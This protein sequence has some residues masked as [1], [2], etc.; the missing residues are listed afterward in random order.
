MAATNYTPISLY[1]STTAS[2]SPL[3]GNLTN[4]ELAINITDGKLFYKDNNGVVQTIAYKNTPISTLSGFGTGVATALG[5]NTGSAG[6]FVVNGGA[7]GTPSSGTL[8]NATGLPVSTGVSGFGTGVATALGINTGSAGAFVVNGGALGTPSSGTVTNLTGT[9]SINI[10]GTVGATTP[11]AG[12]FT[13]LS[14]TGTL[15]GGTGV[16]NIGSGQVYKDASGNVGIGTTSPSSV[17]HAYRAGST[18]VAFKATNGTSNWLFG[19]LSNGMGMVYGPEAQPFGIWTNNTERMRIDSSGNVGIGATSPANKLDIVNNANSA[20]VAKITNTDAGASATAFYQ[21]AS[22]NGN[23]YMIAASTAGGGGAVIYWDGTAQLLLKTYGAYPLAFGTNNTERMRIDSNG[24]VGIGA[25]PGALGSTNRLELITP[26]GTASRLLWGQTS[27]TNYSWSIPASTDAF[28]LVYGASTERMRID[29]SGNVGIGGTPAYRLD[30]QGGTASFTGN[31][32]VSAIRVTGAGG[33]YFWIDNP[34][35]STMRFSSGATPGTGVMVLNDSG[36][37]GIG[38]ASPGGKLEVS[39]Q[40]DFTTVVGAGYGVR[41]RS[42]SG[43]ATPAILQFTDNPVTA[44]WYAIQS[45]SADVL[46]FNNGGGTEKMRIDSSGNV[47]IGTNSPSEKLTV[48]GNATAE[49]YKLRSNTSTPTSTDAFIYRPADNT[50]AFGTASTE[51]ARID[52]SGNVG[53]GTSSPTSIAG[54]QSLTVNGS[55][56]GLISVKYN[57]TDGGY[58]YTD[59]TSFSFDSKA[60]TPNVV[61]KSNGSEKMRIDSSG[62]LGLGVTPSAW[63]NGVSLQGSAWAL[64]TTTGTD[65]SALSTNA[66]QTAYGTGAQNW[67]YRTT[68]PA[69]NYEQTAG[70]HIFHIAPSGTA[71]NAITFTEAIRIDNSGF[72]QFSGNNVMPYQGAPTSKAAATTLTGA[73]LITGILNTTGTTYTITLPTGTNIEG[74]LTWS[75]NNVCLDWFVI[76]TASGTIT[77]AANG[78]TTLGSLTVATGVSAQFRIRRT[79]ANTFTVYRLG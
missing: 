16:I 27:V 74:A 13:N 26:N 3:A 29:S 45:P 79:A 43:S 64:S 46:T 71:G 60:A 34:T 9:A 15:T 38:T 50:L 10:N 33:S 52:S 7:L 23:L 57:G 65:A 40:A 35:T 32:G 51:R 12:S 70:R 37:L 24:N 20:T 25:A 72:T 36:N 8:T 63:G 21:A 31:S 22:N 67:V 18:E 2:A 55:T 5:V 14:Y 62:N 54:Y 30:V 56:S 69:A 28:T 42:P 17:L 66:R 78:N 49:I 53:I 39:G 47:G 44:Q 11:A 59:S 77:I 48:A 58:I 73:E 4:G 19:N 76:N 75:A 6:A 61:F 68:A 1:Y 41:V